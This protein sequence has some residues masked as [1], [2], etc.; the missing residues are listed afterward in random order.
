MNDNTIEIRDDEINVEEIM[1]KIRENIRRRRAAGELA[2][3][4]LQR[5]ALRA[6][7]TM[8]FNVIYHISIPIGIYAIT[9]TSSPPIIPI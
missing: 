5:I 7:R 8:Q 1:E 6:N 3:D 4:P 2:P 9:V